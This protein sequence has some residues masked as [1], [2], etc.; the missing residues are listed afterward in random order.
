MAT[1][2]LTDE[3]FEAAV[4]Q[5]PILLVD[6][7]AAWCGPCRQFAPIYE[8]AS[9]QHPDVTFAKVDTEAEVKIAAAAQITSIPTLMA[10]REGVL[11]FAQPGALPATALEDLIGQV[12]GLDMAQVHAEV[13]R[14]REL[15]DAPVDISA[16]DFA[17]AWTADTPVLD[18]REPA[19]YLSG[20]VPGSQSIP[21]SQ[22][23]ERLDQLP[24]NGP[25]YVICASGNRSR[26][27]TEALRRTG[28]EAY[29]VAGGTSAW[30]AAGREIITGSAASSSD[31]AEQGDPS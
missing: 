9:E 13:A 26:S 4:A 20:H 29:S 10:F 16:E 19:E 12:T 5:Y 27:A 25:L 23:P 17:S 6:F 31:T 1:I 15:L 22:L 18:V 2:N 11:V 14:Q 8:Q 3:T 30:A 24:T 7:W 28:I 21:L